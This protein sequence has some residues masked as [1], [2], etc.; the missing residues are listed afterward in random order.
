MDSVPRVRVRSALDKAMD[1]LAD[2]AVVN[3]RLAGSDEAQAA[4]IRNR[5]EY[6]KRRRRNWELVYQVVTRQEALCTLSAIEEA[7]RKV[8]ELLSEDS[9]E[10]QSVGSLKHQLLELQ[11]EVAQAH[12]RLHAT[13]ARVEQNLRRIN[14]LKAEASKLE[15]LQ[16]KL[17]GGGMHQPAAA[18]AA[19]APATA[20]TQPAAGAAT[21]AASAPALSV[22][23]ATVTTPAAAATVVAAGLAGEAAAAVAP[24]A[25][26]KGPQHPQRGLNASLELEDELRNNWFIVHFTSKL[27][28]VGGPGRDA[29]LAAV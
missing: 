3:E 16:Q 6:L 12:Q 20:A 15:R 29:E 9:R 10:S 23:A 14:E 24:A 8:D 17:G 2:L 22:A 1:Q 28:K 27:G 18:V 25:P 21:A 7:N 26:A 13:R 19:G 11:G 5:L 4:E